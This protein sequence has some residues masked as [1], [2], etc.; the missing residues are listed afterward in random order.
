[1]LGLAPMDR[2]TS[3]DWVGAI[4]CTLSA[5]RDHHDAAASG[6]APAQH[7]PELFHD[8]LSYRVNRAV[9]HM[10]PEL[11]EAAIA[12]YVAHGPIGLKLEALGVPSSTFWERV[13][14]AK[15]YVEAWL[16]CP[17]KLVG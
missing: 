9:Q 17:D 5:V 8:D 12:R 3:S 14:R 4:R 11:R 10:A 7:Y 2:A 1:M 6:T 15:T 16:E 13:G